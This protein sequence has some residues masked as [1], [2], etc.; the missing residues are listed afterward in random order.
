MFKNEKV[1]FILIVAVFAFASPNIS[2]HA[3]EAQ[4]AGQQQEARFDSNQTLAYIGELIGLEGNAS[5]RAEVMR[6]QYSGASQMG[7]TTTSEE[8]AN[9]LAEVLLGDASDQGTEILLQRGIT[10]PDR[11][12]DALEGTIREIPFQRV[13]G[14]ND[15]EPVVPPN[16]IEES[17]DYL[18]RDLG[19]F[20]ANQID[21]PNFEFSEDRELVQQLSLE[22]VT[23]AAIE[24]K[25]ANEEAKNAAE[26]AAANPNDTEAKAKAAETAEKAKQATETVKEKTNEAVKN[27]A[28]PK[29]IV[30]AVEKVAPPEVV[31]TVTEVLTETPA[32][33]EP[34]ANKPDP[35]QNPAPAPAEPAPT[36]PDPVAPPKVDQD[37]PDPD[38]TLTD[39][40]D[41]PTVSAA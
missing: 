41:G 22:A 31:R 13:Y 1:C 29:A 4:I 14:T 16:V 25:T 37:D 3:E 12:Q 30:A 23:V 6:E 10:L 20:R 15:G 7:M 40:A 9:V 5:Q 11:G 39:I 2:I 26:K 34:E 17:P 28:P 38:D 33:K 21:E 19:S 8:V 36:T 35:V 32:A 18:T 27:G 24:A